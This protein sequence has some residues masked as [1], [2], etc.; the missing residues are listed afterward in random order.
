VQEAAAEHQQ[1]AGHFGDLVRSAS[2]DTWDNQS[3]VADWKARDVVGHLVEWFPAFLSGGAGIT[4]PSGPRVTE[5][6][7]AAWTIQTDAIQALLEDP[8]TATR[9]LTNP[10]IGELPLDQAIS[11]FYVGDVFQHTWDLAKATGQSVVLDSERCAGMLEGMMPMD[12]ILRASGQYGPKIAVSPDASAMDQ[13]VG[14]IGRDPN[15]T[16]RA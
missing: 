11:R 8:E 3:P 14:F 7:V 6:P 10:H 13:L 1:I 12:E 9:M 15:W 2:S 5:D 16:P 4:L